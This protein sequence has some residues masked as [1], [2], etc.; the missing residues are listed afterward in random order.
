MHPDQCAL[1]VRL[2]QVDWKVRADEAHAQRCGV[3]AEALLDRGQLGAVEPAAVGV[4]LDIADQRQ[5]RRATVR[6]AVGPAQLAA[7]GQPG[8]R[9]RRMLVHVVRDDLAEL[10]PVVRVFNV[11][12]VVDR[13]PH[14]AVRGDRQS[15]AVAHAGREDGRLSRRAGRDPHDRRPWRSGVAVLRRDVARRSDREVHRTIGTDGDALQRMRIGTAQVR[16]LGV[17]QTGG[18]H[19]L[20][21]GS[22]VGIRVRVDLVAFRD[23]ERHAGERQTVRLVQALQQDRRVRPAG[24]PGRQ[25]EHLTARRHRHQQRAVGCPRGQPGLGNARPHRHGPAG[26]HQRLAG[27][28]QRRVGQFR[29]HADGDRSQAGRCRGCRGGRTRR[30]TRTRRHQ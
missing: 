10:R 22:A 25:A 12:A 28:V 26:G 1:G 5:V 14:R 3:R 24:G 6:I 20:S 11:V 8:D 18:D 30:R 16:A 15:G 13:G 7:R 17:G 29:R 4:G 27:S 2:R 23:I 21:S 19:T 9:F